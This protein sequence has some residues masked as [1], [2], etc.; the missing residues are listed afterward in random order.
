[1]NTAFDFL[2]WAQQRAPQLSRE[3]TALY[4]D[5][6]VQ[7]ETNVER[8]PPAGD[9]L[10]D[11]Y[12]TLRREHR[13]FSLYTPDSPNHSTGERLALLASYRNPGCLIADLIAHSVRRTG[14]YSVSAYMSTAERLNSKCASAFRDLRTHSKAQG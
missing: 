7:L 12:Y 14:A 1:M 6:L 11:R 13:Q 2:S 9:F 5:W 3:L 10:I 8:L 4:N